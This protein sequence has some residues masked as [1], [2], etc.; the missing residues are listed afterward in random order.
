MTSMTDSAN[1]KLL[2]M[3]AGGQIMSLLS[4]CPTPHLVPGTANSVAGKPILYEVVSP[5][6]I[7]SEVVNIYVADVLTSCPL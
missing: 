2:T 7:I 1:I 5:I 6:F 4:L 3:T